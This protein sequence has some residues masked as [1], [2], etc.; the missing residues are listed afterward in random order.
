MDG[1]P[2]KELSMLKRTIATLCILT[3][4]TPLAILPA[5]A[6]GKKTPA[7]VD[8]AV[9]AKEATRL[10]TLG[11][12]AEKM[13]EW[14]DAETYYRQAIAA[15]NDLAGA[16][17]NL[18][19]VLMQQENYMEATNAFRRA[20]D[21]LPSDPTPY[22][23]L[24]L[25]YQRAGYSEDAMRAYSMSLE[26]DPN[27]LPSIRGYATSAKLLNRA[28]DADLDVLRRGLMLDMDPKWRELYNFQRLRIERDIEEK[29]DE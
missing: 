5:C 1:T 26:R 11:R 12:N 20:A 17:N 24:G 9:A 2:H 10:F 21:L 23:N 8:P 15:S 7:P 3:C 13:G 28:D 29:K 19:V 4:V 6:S 27:W 25:T 22:E 18:G 16:W 14:A